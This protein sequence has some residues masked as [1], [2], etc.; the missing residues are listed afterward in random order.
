MIART[1]ICLADNRVH[2]MLGG[3]VAAY[4]S[5]HFGLIVIRFRSARKRLRTPESSESKVQLKHQRI[6]TIR[7]V[8]L[9]QA[10]LVVTLKN[11]HA[12]V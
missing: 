2:G 1:F 3:V 4:S 6:L 11:L 12:H 10:N 7:F 8:S 5:V 9:R